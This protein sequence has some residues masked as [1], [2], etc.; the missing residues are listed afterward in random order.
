MSKD[1]KALSKT[2]SVEGYNELI[3]AFIIKKDLSAG[4]E[5]KQIHPKVYEEAMEAFGPFERVIRAL[6]AK[7]SENA[8]ET[9]RPIMNLAVEEKISQLRE[10]LKPTTTLEA[11][12]AERIV[13]CYLEVNYFDFYITSRYEGWNAPALFLKRQDSAHKRYLSAIKALAQVR[14]LQLPMVQVNIGEN[15]INAGNVALQGR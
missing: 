3:E 13:A 8:H 11:L 7:M 2:K 5:L 1:S 9:E 15:Q 6:Q 12:L 10:N 14:R 4:K